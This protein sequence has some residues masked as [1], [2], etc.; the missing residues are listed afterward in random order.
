M[1]GGRGG[2]RE[3]QRHTGEGGEGQGEEKGKSELLKIMWTFEMP[4]PIP[5]A[6]LVIHLLQHGH[7]S[8]SLPSS[9]TNGD[10][11]FEPMTLW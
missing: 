10:Q 6:S 2:D 7:T 4:K 1:L 8:Q 5:S 3:R 11:A 9:S